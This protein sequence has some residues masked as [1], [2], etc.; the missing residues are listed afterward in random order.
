M[1]IVYEV[2]F[3][4]TYK[5]KEI[6]TT[7]ETEHTFWNEEGVP[8][9]KITNYTRCFEDKQKACEFVMQELQKIVDTNKRRL[10]KSL[11]DLQHFKNEHKTK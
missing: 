1:K 2:S 8:F 3:Y 11:E 4:G 7:R 5:I 9:R 6:K 10:E